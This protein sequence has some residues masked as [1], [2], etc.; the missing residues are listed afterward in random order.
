MHKNLKRKIKNK[1]QILFSRDVKQRPCFFMLFT[2]H[3][4]NPE[5]PE[6]GE[7]EVP[8]QCSLR[9][10]TQ[11]SEGHEIVAGESKSLQ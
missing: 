4:S 9:H 7:T 1:I 5:S 2:P 10:R 11:D 3:L 6:R 8:E